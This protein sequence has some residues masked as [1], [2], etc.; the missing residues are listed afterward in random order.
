MSR[1]V[2]NVRKVVVTGSFDDLRSRHVRLLEEASKLGDVHVLLWP[3][4]TT[5]ALE[6]KLPKFPFEERRYLVQALRYVSAVTPARGMVTRD[7]LPDM[8][9]LCPHIWVTLQ[10]DDTPEKRDFCR[11][12]GLIYKTISDADLAGFPTAQIQTTG[13]PDLKKVVVTGC[14]DWLHSGHVRFFEEVSE[15]GD[16]YVVVGN[17]VNVGFLKGEGHPLFSQEERRYMVQAVRYVHQ[18]LISSGMGWMDAEPEIDS[19][20]PDIYAVN[21]DGDKP[22]K[23]AFCTQHHLEYVVLQRKPKEGLPKRESTILRGF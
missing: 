9:G 13:Q 12:S 6:G 5:L 7:A 18:A 16:L 19:M 21:Q 17:D 8:E 2:S 1:R 3:D 20:Q 11:S 14:F 15:L 10:A 23:R 4:E 22:E